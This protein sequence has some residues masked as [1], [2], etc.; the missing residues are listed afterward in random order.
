MKNTA[1]TSAVVGIRKRG[2]FEMFFF[3]SECLFSTTSRESR[4]C[5]EQ[6]ESDHVLEILE[7]VGLLE[8]LD[9]NLSLS[10]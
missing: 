6:G 9:R 10:Q 8:T 4:E 2:S 5:G 1:L 7:N 3:F